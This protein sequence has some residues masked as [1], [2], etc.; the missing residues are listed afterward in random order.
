VTQLAYRKEV[1]LSSLIV[2]DRMW[3]HVECVYY[4]KICLKFASHHFLLY[5]QFTFAK[6]IE[7]CIYAFKCSQQKCKL[8]SL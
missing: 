1:G 3:R 2:R 5:M 4:D 6:I 8:A 7:F